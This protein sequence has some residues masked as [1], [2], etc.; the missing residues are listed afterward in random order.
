[1]PETPTPLRPPVDA[2]RDHIQ[3]P[4]DAR[5]TLV[6]YG[7]YQCG[8]CRRAHAGIQRLQ[9][10]RLPGQIRYVFRHFPNTRL[11]PDAQ[12]AAEAAEA[13]AAQGRFWDMHNYLFE[14]QDGLDR[15][16]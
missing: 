14:H 13:A 16:V 6:E 8:Y 12:R 5:V 4:A 7:D 15:D 11:H 1:M 3:G 10:E 2:N 9:E